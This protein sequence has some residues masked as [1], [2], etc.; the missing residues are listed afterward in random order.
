MLDLSIIIVNFNG[1]GLLRQCLR[2][3]F[4]CLHNTKIQFKIICVDNNSSDGSV[5]MIREQFASV[6]LVPLEQNGGY[7]KAVNI[8]LR[9]SEARYYLILN[10]DTTIV[11]F[12]AFERMVE[13]MDAHSEIGLAGPKLINPDGSTQVSTCLFPKFL[14]P[15][16]R[17]TFLRK[18]PIARQAIRNYLMLEWNHKDSIPVDWV[19]GTGMIIRNEALQQVGLMDERFFMYFEDV[20]WCR[21]FWQSGWKVYYLS[22]VQIVH[23]YSRGSAKSMG[24]ASIFNKQ[25]RIHISSWMK[26]FTKYIG[27]ETPHAK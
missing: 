11:Q 8:G 4:A 21:R 14:Y 19:I 7:A 10:M 5:A 9:A 24:L 2:S 13:F 25:T 26:Y 16:F 17:R 22:D 3:I 12:R 20:D 15:I 18:L 23:Y 27:K 6:Q 1:R